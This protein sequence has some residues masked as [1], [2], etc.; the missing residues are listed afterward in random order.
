MRAETSLKREECTT[1]HGSNKFVAIVVSLLQEGWGCGKVRERRKRRK[2]KGTTED[3]VEGGKE[4]WREGEEVHDGKLLSL[5]TAKQ[6]FA[7][8]VHLSKACERDVL[9]SIKQKL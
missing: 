9:K 6:Y 8:S 4:K 1:A 5:K 7:I 2:R 3:A